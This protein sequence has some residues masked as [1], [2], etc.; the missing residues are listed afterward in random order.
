LALV[1]DSQKEISTEKRPG[2]R[3]FS[4]PDR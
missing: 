1:K 3:E 4:D 2:V